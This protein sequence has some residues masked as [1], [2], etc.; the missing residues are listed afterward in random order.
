MPIASCMKAGSRPKPRL[1]KQKPLPNVQLAILATAK[2]FL[3]F[4]KAI[5]RYTKLHTGHL[6]NSLALSQLVANIRREQALT[7]EIAGQS[8]LALQQQ[9]EFSRDDDPV[10]NRKLQERCEARVRR[11][12]P[13]SSLWWA[14]EVQT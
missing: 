9:I 13:E 7:K 6:Y 2:P 4:S 11:Q 3:Q 10:V 1:L 5:E 8:D 14:T 12:V